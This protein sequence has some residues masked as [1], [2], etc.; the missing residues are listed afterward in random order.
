MRGTDRHQIGC[1]GEIRCVHVDPENGGR[2]GHVGRIAGRFCR[3]QQQ[4]GLD[5]GGEGLCLAQVVRLQVTPDR[6]R[7]WQQGQPDELMGRQLLREIDDG[8]ADCRR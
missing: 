8:Q 1:L 5:I 3:G 2:R 7:L 4:P 6:E